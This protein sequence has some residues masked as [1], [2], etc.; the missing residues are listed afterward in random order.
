[1][2]I[3]TAGYMSNVF[4]PALNNP[5]SIAQPMINMIK[6]HAR[7]Y[8]SLHQ[9]LDTADFK[10]RVGLAHHLRI[11]DPKH[12]HNPIDRYLARKFDA[13]FNWAIPEALDSGYFN[14]SIPFMLRASAFIPEA[15]GT[16]DF[17]G[18]NYYSR[19]RINFN[20]FEKQP[21]VR[22]VTPGA[23]LT[24]LGWEIYPEGMGRIIDKVHDR[25]PKLSIYLTENGMADATDV[26]RIPFVRE[27][28]K[29][30]SS[31]I[32]NGVKVEGYCH[33]TL[34]DN[35]EW[36]EGYA[37][38]FGLFAL[39]PGTLKRIPKPSAALFSS[40]IQETK[41]NPDKPLTSISH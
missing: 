32:K 13:V 3:I 23:D 1:M 38:K 12:S 5:K 39:E 21:L 37:P 6:A 11:F 15:I 4:P 30:I 24:D 36:A 16:Q 20:L 33:W 26:K 41:Q 14:V 27:H 25:Y 17:F 8:H 7:A 34:N 35:F 9:I 28:L 31:Q 29:E 10:P 18:L 40:L 2:T 19:D 22:S